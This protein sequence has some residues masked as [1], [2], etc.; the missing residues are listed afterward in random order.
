MGAQQGWDSGSR[1][2]LPAPRW[3]VYFPLPWHPQKAKRTA[4]PR[5]KERQRTGAGVCAD[6]QVR[7]TES[8]QVTTGQ[9]SRL[10]TP[11]H[12]LI[13]AFDSCSSGSRYPT[14]SA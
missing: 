9:R 14:K 12:D 6:G 8:S 2:T 10:R 1:R 3:T 4:H 7:C 5:L 11:D 13:S